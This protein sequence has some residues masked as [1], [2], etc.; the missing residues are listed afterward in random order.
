[1]VWTWCVCLVGVGVRQ[2]DEDPEY[3]FSDNFRGNKKSNLQRQ[4]LMQR[5]SIKLNALMSNKARDLGGNAILAYQVGTP[6]SRLRA[7]CHQAHPLLCSAFAFVLHPQQHFDFEG[8]SGIVGRAYGTAFRWVYCVRMPSRCPRSTPSQAV[9][10]T[11]S[12]VCLFAPPAVVVPAL[13]PRAMLWSWT[14]SHGP[15][16]VH[17]ATPADC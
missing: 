2:V 13:C 12:Q 9:C 7:Q 17:P 1:M 15:P 4:L 5:L 11:S 14:P 6:P 10:L 16:L 8:D 3:E